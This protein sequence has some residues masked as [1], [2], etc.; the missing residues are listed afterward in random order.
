MGVDGVDF[1]NFERN[2]DKFAYS[3]CNRIRNGRYFF[4]PFLEVAVSKDPSLDRAEAIAANK[5]RCISIATIK[6][7]IMQRLLYRELEPIVEE[8]FREIP[9]VSYAYRRGL[10]APTAVRKIHEYVTNDEYLYVLDADLSKFFDTIPHDKLFCSIEDFFGA[11]NV[12]TLKLIRRFYSADRV[13]WDEHPKELKDYK[14]LKPKRTVRKENGIRQGIPQ[15]GVLSGMLANIYMHSFDKWVIDTLAS[16]F[17]I[18]YVRYADDFV[19]LFKEK[20]QEQ[21]VFNR[22]KDKLLEMGLIIHNIGEKT[23]FI[24]LSLEK[25]ERLEFVGFEVI[26]GRIRVREANIQKFKNRINEILDKC[27]VPRSVDR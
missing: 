23:K 15:G 3:I 27:G 7:V 8:R 26:P 19:V 13:L 12:L 16:S 9:I 10:S 22:I 17:D 2:L 14:V 18:K 20:G 21:E 24:D 4:S 5:F 6:D 25:K 11:G 1:Q